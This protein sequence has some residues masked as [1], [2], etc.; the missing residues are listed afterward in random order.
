MHK[1][2][3]ALGLAAAL[4]GLL[5][6]TARA[7]DSDIFGTDVQPNVLL[8]VDN[9]G[10]MDDTIY[11]DPYD[12]NQSPAYAASNLCSPACV[13]GKVYKKT[14]SHGNDV[15]SIYKDTIADVNSSSA[16]S[17]LTTDGYWSGRIS[18]S[19]VSL[20]TGNYLNWLATPGSTLVRKIDVAKRVLIKLITNTENVRFGL[21]TFTGNSNEGHGGGKILAPIGS[22]VSTLTTAINNLTPDGYTPL[23]EM[24]RDAGKYYKG[25]G[26]YNGNY[27][28]SPIQLGCQPNFVIMMSDGLQNGSVDVR[29]EATLRRTQD[30]STY[31]SGVQNVFVDTIGF[32]I[33]S[34]ESAAANDVLQTE[35]ANGG[36][37]FYST[38]NETQLEAA[39]EDAIRQILAATFAFAT[40][41][42]PTTNAT[43]VS[44]T[45]MA[46]FQSDPAK[47]FWRG[48]L[49]AFNQDASGNVV[50]AADG[51]PDVSSTCFV[52]P[53]ANT[54]P[55]LAWE[56]GQVLSTTS[57][58]SRT[59]YTYVNG[60]LQEFKTTTTDITAALLGVSSADRDKLINFIRGIDT[61]DE[62]GNGNTTEER[63]WKLGDI[64]HS[65][66]VL[67]TP[68]LA[69][70]TDA[71][72]NSFKTET[73]PRNVKNRPTILIAGAND[74][75]L[76]AYRQDT[77]AELWAF[78]PPNLLGSLK[79]L[80]VSGG[81]HNFYV[82]GSP[83]AADV[84]TRTPTDATVK[85]RT[86]LIFGERRGGQ[87]YYA[88]DISDGS[89]Q[90]LWEFK[91][92]TDTTTTDP[93]LGETWSTPAIGKV[94][95]KDAADKYV[96]FV[97]GG[98][99]S[100][101]NNRTGRAV[102][103]IDIGTGTKLWKYYHA[104]GATDDSQYMNFSI[105]APVTQVDIN[106][107]D[108]YIDGLY[109]G[110]IAGQVWKFNLN[111]DLDSN[112]NPLGATFSGS[113]VNNWQGKRVFAAPLASGTT[114]PPAAGEYYP[115]Q[116]IYGAIMPSFDNANPKN[117][118]IF[119]GTGD[120]NHPNSATA[121]NLFFGIKDN[122]TMTNGSTLTLTQSALADVTWTTTTVSQG[123]YIQLASSEKVLDT[124]TIFN[125]IAFFTTFTPGTTTA[126]L[127]GGGTAKI[128]AVLMIT[129]YGA[130]DWNAGKTTGSAT[131]YTTSDASN[132]RSTDI[133]VGIP[134]RP[135]M[136]TT[137]SGSSISTAGI[138]ST[139]SGQLPTNPVPSPSNMRRTVY[140]REIFN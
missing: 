16:R 65:S 72:Y 47:P 76:H 42:I 83:V 79:L 80:A 53:P 69:P 92:G 30:H 82:D 3:F 9:S 43:G 29:T 28:T 74:G 102:F 98:Y 32:A 106:P 68:P 31:F 77:G 70:S 21:M 6:A 59:I 109:V 93:E 123:Y 62:N 64:F 48:F 44:R 81:D 125:N 138:A 17:A 87:A 113:L 124:A 135:I 128:Y 114:N 137:E 27:T 37:T 23:G 85:W 118:W 18:G 52:D 88:L 2:L 38:D 60:S 104:S 56:A 39:L 100:A 22:S 58:A 103:A 33:G 96:T 49:K 129:G 78:I 13:T 133:G 107:T 73:S 130:L 8:A 116:A 126:C 110:D 71:S 89:P 121:I 5:V 75:M 57:A 94:K 40:P 26:D 4:V 54:I 11:S 24:L 46:E 35:A 136:V 61:Y 45:F 95:I 12:P 117:V 115:A 7:D 55:C 132:V 101:Q 19:N 36:G 50:L 91:Q 108:G 51:T 112:G 120:R 20:F 134:S 86:V 66:P 127:G 34:D 139:S 90:Y 63:A 67:V 15:Y 105:P 131:P 119:F 10:S 97:G 111:G 25:Q 14:T 41:V 1:Q 122:T 84:Y 99:D 140:W